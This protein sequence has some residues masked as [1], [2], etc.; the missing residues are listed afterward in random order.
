LLLHEEVRFGGREAALFKLMDEEQYAADRMHPSCCSRP[1]SRWTR[2]LV[3]AI[4]FA[5]VIAIAAVTTHGG[6]APSGEAPAGSR[7]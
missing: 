4:V 3:V 1:K 5:A 2:W 7:P 6:V